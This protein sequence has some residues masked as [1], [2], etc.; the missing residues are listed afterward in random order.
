MSKSKLKLPKEHPYR[1]GRVCTECNTFKAASQY[2]LER[3]KR[4]CGGIAM[5]S[6]CKPC[7]ESIKYK[8]FIKRTY[9]ITYDDYTK[10]LDQQSNACSICKSKI[11]STRTSRL[12]VDH[13]H[14]TG[15]VRGL[16]CSSCNHG[17]GLFKDSPT[18][19]KRAIGYL[20]SDRD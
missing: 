16:L 15:K 2:T 17:L 1:D 4:A 12:F 5:R 3:D 6:K 7:N 14:T 11:S 13:C 18:L 8:S 20:E 9:G 19:L 10:M